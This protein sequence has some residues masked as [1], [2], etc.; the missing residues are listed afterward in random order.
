MVSVFHLLTSPGVA[1][2]QLLPALADAA[3]KGIVVFGV[4]AFAVALCRRRSAATRHAIWAGAVAAQLTLPALSTVLP[5]WRVP[6][7]ERLD[8]RLATPVPSEVLITPER[9]VIAGPTTI[10]IGP[11]AS[12]GIVVRRGFGVGRTH[13]SYITPSIVHSGRTGD[14]YAVGA[15]DW[16]IRQQPR[17]S[18]VDALR[19]LRN[20]TPAWWV[21]AAA[22]V[23]L[24]GALGIFGRFVAGTLAVSRLARRSERVEDGRW[25]SLAQHIA[26]RLGVAR[27]MTLLRSGRF[28]I[29]VTWGI[30]Y[31]V[32]LLPD[33]ADDWTDERRRYVLVHEMAHVKRVDAFTQVIAQLAIAIFWF[34]P[35]VWIAAHRMRV[36]REHACDDYVLNEGTPASTYAADLLD[37]VRSLGTRGRTA[38]PAFA[39]LAMA[40]PDELETRMQAI[41]DPAQDRQSLRSAPALGLALCS[42]LLLLPLAAFRPMGRPVRSF[43]SRN[44]VPA[45]APV[46]IPEISVLPEL[47]DFASVPPRTWTELNERLRGAQAAFEGVKAA[48]AASAAAVAQ[49][50]AAVEARIAASAA[51]AVTEASV[52]TPAVAS[53]SGSR[54]SSCSS[55][56]LKRTGNSTSI[57]SSSDDDDTSFQY[58]SSSAG[59]CVQVAVWGHVEFS[60]DERSIQS[61]SRDGRLYIRERRPKMDREVEITPGDEDS[62]RYAYSVD[63]E[64]A[65]F[66]EDGRAWL[67]EL[68]PE[69]LR[70]SGLNAREHVARLRR[71][72]GIDAVLA[73]ISRTESTSAKR[74]AYDALLHQGNLSDEDAA[75]IARQAGSDLSSSD[76]ELR[77]VLEQIGKTGHMSSPMAQAFSSAVEHM[78][79]DGE[80]RAL[81]QQYALAGDREMLLVAMRQARSISSD[82]EK[83]EFLR[84]T[85]NK[86]V[87]GEDEAL[88]KAYF[89]VTQTI[90]SDGEKRNVLNETLPYAQRAAVLLSVLESARQISSDGEKSELLMAILRRHL[91]TTSA[92]REAFMQ[93]TRTLSSD[94]EYRRVMEV[95]L[96]S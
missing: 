86:Y 22:V 91:L 36:E 17:F 80:K 41:L 43:G 87:A 70:E 13:A 29:P 11:G 69:I 90:S 32:V 81:L 52:A 64:R 44:W 16:I 57:H 73:D 67:E 7:I 23:W 49:A 47:P 68:L 50:S 38:Q 85:T 31:P 62:P 25:L 78:S 20:H 92:L 8:R 12:G 65:S 84:A 60:R 72:G 4:A 61:L 19:S 59:R 56:S 30:V 48:R 21:R 89:D 74:A 39:A 51:S 6:L 27:P 93:I 88:R 33:N 42:L 53:W 14:V 96:A 40:R 77:A 45:P 46:V 63:G 15:G 18:F 82:G 55:V 10:S 35:F 54:N 26:I 76:G 66:D 2:I 34:D 58:I 24:L 9:P 37:M 75:R 28:E 83:A 94:A 79:S 95:A 3:I 5:A 1:A 71:E